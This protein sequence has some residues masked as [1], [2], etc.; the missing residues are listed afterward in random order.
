MAQ[1]STFAEG[2]A[3]TLGIHITFDTLN[4]FA[5]ATGELSLIVPG[6]PD[7]KGTQL[8]LST[9][10]KAEKRHLKKCVTAL[11]WCLNRHTRTKVVE[12][13]SSTLVAVVGRQST[14]VLDLL[15][16]DSSHYSIEVTSDTEDLRLAHVLSS[17]S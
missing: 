11:K 14:F 2:E 13:P 16:D 10:S 6:M 7:T 12:A 9:R 3:F 15:K 1:S 8:T 17:S 4:F 5:T